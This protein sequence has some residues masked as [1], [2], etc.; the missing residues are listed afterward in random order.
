MRPFPAYASL[1]PA[2]LPGVA[3]ASAFASES[4]LGIHPPLAIWGAIGCLWAFWYLPEMSHT[5]RFLSVGIAALVSSALSGP[6]AGVGA[7]ALTHFF[8]WWPESVTAG[9]LAEPVA[10]LLGFLCHTTLG[11]RLSR[12]GFSRK[13]FCQGEGDGHP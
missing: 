10:L 12:L 7:A 6:L 11:K 13:D 4:F 2:I 3:F 1:G 5:R 9:A 8:T